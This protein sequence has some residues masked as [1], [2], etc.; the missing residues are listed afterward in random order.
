MMSRSP[1]DRQ[2]DG[3]PPS[4]PR[5]RVAAPDEQ[6]ERCQVMPTTASPVRAGEV[7]RRDRARLRQRDDHEKTRAIATSGTTRSLRRR[8]SRAGS[9]P[10]LVDHRQGHLQNA[11]RRRRRAGCGQAPAEQRIALAH[12]RRSPP[13]R[14]SGPS[15]SS[16][17]SSHDRD[18]RTTAP[19]QSARAAVVDR[20]AQRLAEDRR[21]PCRC[22]A[23]GRGRPF[24][25]QCQSRR[26]ARASR[27]SAA[28]I[29]RIDGCGR[30]ASSSSP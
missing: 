4:R 5:G 20:R 14:E 27:P 19:S 7:G 6:R 11:A 26:R 24:H 25:L 29:R 3:R 30:S 15:A 21:P 8:G 17:S 2:E 9:S 12:A 13:A 18:V 10:R 28:A 22:R 23:T 1:M 16:R